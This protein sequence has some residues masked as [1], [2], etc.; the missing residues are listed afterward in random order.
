MRTRHSCELSPAELG[1]A[2]RQWY[3]TSLGGV[4]LGHLKG[5]LDNLLPQLFGYHVLQIGHVAPELN[6]LASSRIKHR[7]VM[8][9]SA[10]DA[11][12]L[13]SPNALPFQEDSLDLI[14]LLH[15]LDFAREPHRVLREVDRTLIPEGHAIIIGFNPVSFYGLGKLLLQWR[16]RVPWC[17][18][19]YTRSRVKDWLSLLGFQTLASEYFGY[20]PP[21][22]HR[23]FQQ[24]LEFVERIGTFT[25]PY[26]GGLYVMLAQKKLATLTPVRTRWRATRTLLPGNLTEPTTRRRHGG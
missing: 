7:I 19:F 1:V 9:P 18:R 2:L 5:Q 23:G 14:L 4:L 26:V 21:I 15:S 12:V 10:G 20:S 6:L 25:V 17:G 13:G 22:N 3:A 11:A 24:Q 8:D 16:N